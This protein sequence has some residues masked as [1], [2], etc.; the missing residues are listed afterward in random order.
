MVFG[1]KTLG[2]WVQYIHQPFFAGKSSEC[3]YS[4]CIYE[5]AC[6]ISVWARGR[7]DVWPTW[8]LNFW[9]TVGFIFQW[10]WTKYNQHAF[11]STVQLWLLSMDDARGQYVTMAQQMSV[12]SNLLKLIS[13]YDLGRAEYRLYSDHK[14]MKL[15]AIGDEVTT[16]SN[17]SA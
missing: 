9:M 10:I 17:P 12:N 7:T 6:L 14:T 8:T 3:E 11:T 5:T 1:L 2:S 13:M 16:L 4:H 15:P